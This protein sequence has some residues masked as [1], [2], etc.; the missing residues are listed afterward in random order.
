M[1]QWYP[2]HYRIGAAPLI[3]AAMV[4]VALLGRLALPGSAL[5]VWPLVAALPVICL[6]HLY[7][8]IDDEAMNKLDALFYALVHLPL[9][10]VVWTF[11]LIHASGGSLF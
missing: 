6:L 5:V 2:V 7:L 1:L 3:T 9:A 11:C 4:L 10:F 8:I